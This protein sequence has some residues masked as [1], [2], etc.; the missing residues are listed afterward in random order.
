MKRWIAVLLSALLLFSVSGAALAAGPEASPETSDTI[1]ISSAEELAE[2]L[3][4]F[5]KPVTVCE[6]IKAG[7]SAA[8]DAA[9]PEGMV[10]AVGSLYMVG[11]IRACFDLY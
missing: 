5:G 11:E 4:T 7:V 6:S 10:C 8:I 2:L 9:G 1:R 3:R